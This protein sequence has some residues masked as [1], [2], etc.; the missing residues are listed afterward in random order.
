MEK[1]ALRAKNIYI[2]PYPPP[3]FVENKALAKTTVETKELT[4]WGPSLLRHKQCGF[5][6]EIEP[7]STSTQSS[8]LN[9]S[10]AAAIFS[11]R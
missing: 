8:A 4:G 7:D 1:K 5:H 10:E 11:S 2:P 9:F 3:R 6:R